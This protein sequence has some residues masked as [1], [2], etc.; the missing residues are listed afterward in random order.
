ML[1]LSYHQSFYTNK[2]WYIIRI[3]PNI[4]T[5][6]DHRMALSVAPLGL[7]VPITINDPDV[8]SK[9]FPEYWNN[10]SQLGFNLKNLN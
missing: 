5:Y 10:L 7:I 1:L 8:I 9:S 6:N 3:F 4:D 2:G